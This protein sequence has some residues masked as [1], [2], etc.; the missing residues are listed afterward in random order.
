MVLGPNARLS[1]PA[2]VA[3]GFPFVGEGERDSIANEMVERK[4]KEG[5]KLRTCE[6]CIPLLGCDAF[7]VCVCSRVETA[8]LAFL[9]SKGNGN[10][11]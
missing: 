8:M 3:D 6:R 2:S 4:G 11:K 9:G 10:G 7:G 5:D 1:H